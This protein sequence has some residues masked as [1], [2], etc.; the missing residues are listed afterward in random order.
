MARRATKEREKELERA[1]SEAL[2]ALWDI[3]GICDLLHQEQTIGE[4]SFPEHVAAAIRMI[5]YRAGAVSK[6]IEVVP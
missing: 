4:A 2:M 5:D 1:L 3:S 6:Q